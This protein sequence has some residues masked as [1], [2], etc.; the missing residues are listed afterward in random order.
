M[1]SFC[2]YVCSRC[3]FGS[4]ATLDFYDP[5]LSLFVGLR[6]WFGLVWFGLDWCVWFGVDGDFSWGA[7]DRLYL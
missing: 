5:I 6:R 7:Y 1:C 4:N 2:W 3:F